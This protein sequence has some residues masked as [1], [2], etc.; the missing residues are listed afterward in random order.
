MRVL[1]EIGVEHASLRTMFRSLKRCASA[2]Y[3]DT[4]ATACFEHAT[5]AGDLSLCLY[6]VTTLYFEAEQ[7]DDL[8]KVGYSKERRVDPQIVVGLLVDRQ[9]FPL[10]IGCY[11]GNQAETATIVPI[12]TQF[13]ERHGLADMVVVADA[14][15]LS[16]ENLGK[17]DE[18]NLRFIVGS[19]VVKAP[20][21]LA[22][23][24]HWRG[25]AFADGQVIDTIT[26]R[27]VS[28]AAKAENDPNKAAEPVWDRQDNPLSWRAAWAY[29][30]K[31]AVRDAKTLTIQQQRAQAVVDG[32][33]APKKPRFVKTIDG[34]TELDQSGLDR[35][36]RL[37]GL[38][39]YVTN[40]PN[41][42][43]PAAEV[44]AKY[45]DLWQVE[46]SFRMSKTDLRARPIFHDDRDAI[47]AHLTI[48]F[49]ALAISRH[50]Q[51]QTGISIKSI[52]RTLR[53]L[54]QIT[55]R[56]AGHQHVAA[57]PLN[58]LAAEILAAT[59]TTWPTH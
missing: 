14:G 58:P 31:R 20:G 27:R 22:K 45:H 1:D 23:H 12:V 21:D 16:A 10:E 57:D 59:G 33:R 41:A 49:A 28:A 54:Q 24:F 15:M 19:R 11:E 13:Q 29:S 37:V 3:R 8:R 35:A 52:V 6:D 50:L 17:L 48:V 30:R 39:G 32:E 51:Q 5:T 53:P 18:A 34:A 43:M 36:R 26:P 47:E 42:T 40:I 46:A 2:E 25:D 38:K 7:E 4:L 9:G 56:I 55:V 44:I